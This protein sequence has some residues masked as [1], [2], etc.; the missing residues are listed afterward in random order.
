MDELASSASLR[1]RM[2]EAGLRRYE[3]QFRLQHMVDQYKHIAL[4]LAKPVV[5]V[6]MDGCLVDWDR[7]FLQAWN[8]R[9]PV[10]R[11]HYEMEKCV[12][13]DRYNQAV[14]L[15]ESEG[16][17]RGLP[18]MPGGVDALKRIVAA[19]FDVF[20][21][22]SPVA[23]SKYCA[24]EK[25]EWVRE[26]L[27][28]AWLKRL[29]LTC[30]KTTVRGDFLIDDKPSIT[31]SQQPLWKQ[32]LFNAPYNQKLNLGSRRRLHSWDDVEAILF[33]EFAG[34]VEEESDESTDDCVPSNGMKPSSSASSMTS[35]DVALLRDF[36]H[37]LEGTTYMKDYKNWRKGAAQGAKGDFRQAVADIESIRRQMFLE[38][39]DW[40][41]VHTYRSDYQ[42]WRKGKCRGA[43]APK[44][45]NTLLGAI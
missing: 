38:G 2:G 29:I 16:F 23:S 21:C 7:G 40:S 1:Q 35:E 14:E 24:Q 31:G 12:P 8:G 45:E 5:L 44:L 17:F 22:T 13:A 27:G 33:D 9:T 10:D 41:S 32:I 43:K 6:D 3:R 15:F 36:S 28:D 20:L 34:R 18:E 30:D 26:H 19:G 37:E 11:S 39:D 25:W 42:N 4:R